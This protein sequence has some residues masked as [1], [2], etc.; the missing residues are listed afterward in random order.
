M[1][2][3]GRPQRSLATQLQA[4]CSSPLLGT[5]ADK[6]L[7]PPGPS[8]FCPQPAQMETTHGV[9]LQAGPLS[10]RPVSGHSPL[11]GRAES[12]V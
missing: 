6:S 1:L 4:L 11:Q 10:T 12:P 8:S 7:P 2:S 3:D 9:W 5:L